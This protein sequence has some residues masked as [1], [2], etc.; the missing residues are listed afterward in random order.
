MADSVPEGFSFS[1]KLHSSM[2]HSLDAKKSQ[3]VA[4]RR[5]LVPFVQ[6]NRMGAV[7]AQFPWSFPFREKS[8][9]HLVYIRENLADMKVAVEFRHKK[10][11]TV[12]S[13]NRLIGMGFT[14]V[15]V[16][17]PGLPGLPDTGLIDDGTVVYLRLHGRNSGNWWGNTQQRYDY[18]YT[19]GE[20]AALAEK[21]QRLSKG[22]KSCYVFFNNCH[23]GK[24]ALNAADMQ[25]LLTETE[26]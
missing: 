25:K 20:L 1:V 2:T 12:E 3:W 7:L 26:E 6:S 8:F 4:F 17:L 15:S 11:Y 18:L 22:V 5:M 14:P 23:M 19:G 16:D 21:L 13:L 24:A 10:W 9:S